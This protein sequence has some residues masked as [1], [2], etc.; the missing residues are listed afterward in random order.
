MTKQQSWPF[1]S[2]LWW[3]HTSA[4]Q[5]KNFNEEPS[6]PLGDEENGEAADYGKPTTKTTEEEEEVVA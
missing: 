5:Q 2:L 3:R 1:R 4:L 6:L